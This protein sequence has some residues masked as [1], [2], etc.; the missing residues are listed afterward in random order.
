MAIGK[1]PFSLGCCCQGNDEPPPPAGCCCLN[2]SPDPSITSEIDCI[3]QGG[4]WTPDISCDDVD[5]SGGGGGCV[6]GCDVTIPAPGQFSPWWT[7]LSSSYDRSTGDWSVV[8]RTLI[9]GGYSSGRVYSVGGANAV[10][11]SHTPPANG[12]G[13]P[14]YPAGVTV[15]ILGTS[16][17]PTDLT[18]GDW[19]FGALTF[20]V[21]F[22]SYAFTSE[23]C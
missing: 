11:T 3:A 20:A 8:A 18:C 15:T 14:P 2:G 16:T 13:L 17:P 10:V 22:L 19:E 6:D 7:I 23:P 9:D 12:F 21:V 4:I 5:C 1:G